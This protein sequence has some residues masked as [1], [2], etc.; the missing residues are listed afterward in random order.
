MVI[1][2][3]WCY[4]TLL[5]TDGQWK[6]ENFVVS[7]VQSPHCHHAAEIFIYR[8]LYMKK[9]TSVSSCDAIN[10]SASA[11]RAKNLWQP[12]R[13]QQLSALLATAS[14]LLTAAL[15]NFGF[16]QHA[17]TWAW[18]SVIP[19]KKGQSQE[20][21]LVTYCSTTRWPRQLLCMTC[22]FQLWRKGWGS[23]WDKHA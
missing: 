8:S 4:S 21:E 15:K 2:L 14:L 6:D 17:S 18:A 9:I 16:Y 13:A 11:I 23:V 19:S 12:W 1:I 5:S 3:V 7:F 22:L 20:Q 10:P